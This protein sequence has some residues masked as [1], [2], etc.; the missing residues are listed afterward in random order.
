VKTE[1]LVKMAN[2]IGAFFES[3]AGADG[4]AA[5][6]ANHMKRFWDPR[7]RK[8]IVAHGAAGGVGLHDHVRQAVALLAE[9]G[10]K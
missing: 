6:V 2:D 4:A 1:Y 9:E 5:A 3:E 7:M 8:Q 10:K